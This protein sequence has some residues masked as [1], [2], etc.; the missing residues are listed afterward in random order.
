M[1]SF[2]RTIGHLVAV[3]GLVLMSMALTSEMQPVG[4]AT[5]LA[6][7]YVSYINGVN[8]YDPITGVPW[9]KNGIV[10]MDCGKKYNGGRA[11][12]DTTDTYSW[13]IVGGNFG[14]TTGT[15]TLA[16]RAARITSW[17]STQI[18][19]YPYLPYNVGPMSTYLTISTVNGTV[20][21]P[22]SVVP[23]IKSR[24]FGQ[25]TH[26]VAYKRKTLGL[27]P[28]PSAYGGYSTFTTSY[29]PRVGDQL[30]WSGKHTAIIVAVYA[31][32]DGGWSRYN[33]QVSEQNYDCA[34]SIRTFWDYFEVGTINGTPKTTHYITHPSMGRASSYYR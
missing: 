8:V 29:A 11:V 25:C 30:Q 15:V 19:A 5:L 1:K 10:N 28:S 3:A 21:Y 20:N 31:Y 16:G 26:H 13:T 17:S 18:V 14:T 27:A 9:I 2:T 23:A 34:N 7:P 24:V 33:V 4:A 32:Y 22:V 6:A 12:N